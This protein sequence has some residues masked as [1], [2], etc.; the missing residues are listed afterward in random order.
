[1]SKW[2]IFFFFPHAGHKFVIISLMRDMQWVSSG[3]DKKNTHTQKQRIS[4]NLFDPRFELPL[5]QNPKSG[6]KKLMKLR[7][8]AS[9]GSAN[10]LKFR[11]ESEIQAK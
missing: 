9:S 10:P 2:C 4:D 5:K 11:S 6:P 3:R 7:I 1:M 8:A